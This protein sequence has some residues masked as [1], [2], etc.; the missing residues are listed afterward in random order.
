MSPRLGRE[1]ALAGLLEG[2]RAGELD[3]N[4]PPEK[5]RKD[6]EEM[7]AGLPADPA[8]VF[9]RVDLG[10]VSTLRGTYPGGATDGALL[11]FHGGGFVIGSA[12][13]YRLL[14]AEL[15]R[16]AGLTAYAPDYRLAPEHP[17]PAAI[18]DC[19]AAYLAL[20]AQGIAPERIVLAG[21]SAGGGLVISTL[22]A[23]RDAGDPLPA[24]AVA[25]S[26]WVDLSGTSRSTSAKA[27]EDAALTGDGLQACVRHYI[28]DG[29]RNHPLA[30][31]IHADLSGLPPVMIQ[32]GSAE[33]LLDDALALAAAAGHAGTAVR[34]EIWPNMPHVW[35]AFAFMLEAG[36]LAIADAGVFM[37]QALQD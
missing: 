35:H 14:A 12:Q 24:A 31:P 3:F 26:P 36:Q 37:K 7:L 19:R 23:L 25:L 4:D 32:V 20:L 1:P 34:L 30:S 6:F 29:N 10:G 18:D 21:D 22:L 8:L 16:S 13:A 27:A 33:I 9:D 5:A 28:G 11:Y 15:A 17:F 2:L